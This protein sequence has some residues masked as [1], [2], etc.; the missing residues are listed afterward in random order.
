[1]CHARTAGVSCWVSTRRADSSLPELVDKKGNPI[2]LQVSIRRAD[3]SLPE[4]R[5]LAQPEA[6]RP[7]GFNPPRGFF[8]ARTRAS[9]TSA[10]TSARVSIRRAR[11]ALNI[12]SKS[13]DDGGS[14]I[15]VA[16][17]L[18][19]DAGFSIAVA[20]SRPPSDSP[21]FVRSAATANVDPP[22]SSVSRCGMMMLPNP[23]HRCPET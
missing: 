13:P 11:G 19:T 21:S 17:S 5:S 12:R 23:T 9:V 20:L 14:S 22:S 6:F 10:C 2:E 18:A 1:M 15:S 4:Q 8:A 3:S 7:L 16:R